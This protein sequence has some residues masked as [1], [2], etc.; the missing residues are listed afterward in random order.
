MSEVG[1]SSEIRPEIEQ[2]AVSAETPKTAEVEKTSLDVILVFGQ[3]PVIEKETKQ[4]VSEVAETG[5]AEDVN[6]WSKEMAKA[7]CELYKRG[8]TRE[9]IVM[10]G[11]TGGEGYQSEADLIAKEM[12]ALGVPKNAIKKE[13]RSTNTLENIVN[14]LNTYLDKDRDMKKLGVLAANYHVPRIR[15]LMNLFDI[16]YKTAFSAEEVARYKARLGENWD[17]QELTELERRLDMNEAAKKDS[18]YSAKLGT[19]KK[20]IS[21][22]G[23]EEDFFDRALVEVPEYWIGYLGRLENTQRMR[24]ILAKQDQE[25]LAQ[26]FD[27]RLSD[28]DEVLKTKLLS[29]KRIVPPIGEWIGQNWSEETGN[30]IANLATNRDAN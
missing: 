7:A 30:K 28:S 22:R 1:D 12:E 24:S 16:P 27:I 26:K 25:M 23:T 11:K 4:K 3:G 20:N 5:A 21:R 2:K 13:D 29:I 15:M 17:N 9:I 19:E 8:Q 6:L 18:Y 10:G 14:V